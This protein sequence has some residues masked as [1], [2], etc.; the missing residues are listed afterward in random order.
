MISENM[1]VKVVE[2]ICA[3]P[4]RMD[5]IPEDSTPDTVI[6]FKGEQFPI[7]RRHF[8]RISRRVRRIGFTDELIITSEVSRESVIE[9][10]NACEHRQFVVSRD[11]AFDLDILSE[12]W[13]IPSLESIVCE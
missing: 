1:I 10:V 3:P 12:E 13:E 8:S 5:P 11:T 9:F 2:M 6:H 7:L 4:T